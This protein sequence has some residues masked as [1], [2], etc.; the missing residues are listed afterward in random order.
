MR[1][2]SFIAKVMRFLGA[3]CM[4]IAKPRRIVCQTYPFARER[5]WVPEV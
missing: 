4:E 5:Y 1:W 3:N 2:R